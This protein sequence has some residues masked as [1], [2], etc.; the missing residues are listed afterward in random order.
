MS[1]KSWIIIIAET[2]VFLFLLGSV[3]KCSNDRI[4]ILE[5]NIRA[6]KGQIEYVEMQNGELIAAKQSLILSEEELKTEL[7][8]SKKELK[9]LKKKLDDDIAYIAKLQ[10]QI[11][12]KDTVFMKGDTVFVE[13]GYTTKQFY[14][15]DKWTSIFASV[16]G[17]DIA[18]S[19]LFIESFNMD[20]P[21]E[22]GITDDY[23]FWAK[24]SNPYINF[25]DIQGAVVHGSEANKKE[26]RF[27]HGIYV[28]FGIHYGMFGKQ[29][30]FGP[31]GGYGFTYS[32]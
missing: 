17:L 26:K 18:D 23:R 10:E 11:E 9:D 4:D 21:L 15:E 25:T 7:N 13:K 2:L 31:S 20:V 22:V 16:K 28:G 5:H 14:W 6:Y 29:W 27:H 30:D 3:I 19:E 12:L 8:I 32:F 24:T 1:K